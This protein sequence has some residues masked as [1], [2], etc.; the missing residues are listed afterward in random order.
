MFAA[1]YK[2]ITIII[3]LLVS[4]FYFSFT[5]FPQYITKLHCLH[6]IYHF[7]PP[8][9]ALQI[10]MVTGYRLIGMLSIMPPL[11]VSSKVASQ[12]SKDAIILSF[13]LAFIGN[14]VTTWL[15]TLLPPIL[16]KRGIFGYDIN[17]R[18]TDAG[19][20]KV[21]EAAGLAPGV[22]FLVCFIFSQQ[23]HYYNASYI[24]SNPIDFIF[25]R[26]EIPRETMA[27]WLVNYNAALATVG[28]ML[29]LGFVDDVLE[30][31]WRVKLV[32]PTIASLPISVAYNGARFI[33]VPTAL[34]W[35]VGGAAGVDIGIL[36]NIYMVMLTIFCTNSI[37]ILAGINGLEAGQSF[38]IA[39]A[40]LLF[41]LLHLS[42]IREVDDAM[43][44]GHLFSA[45]M[46][47]P[48]AACTFA[49]LKVNYYPAK[50][51]VGDTFT[52]FAGATFAVAG[53]LGHYSEILLIF[54]IP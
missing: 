43:L 6:S 10:T 32:L 53:I 38:I 7:P 12:Q 22:G 41:N 15:L 47:I 35:L 34:Q 48:F 31:P 17:K 4:P 29:F 11:L 14:L 1:P 26:P 40:V 50:M 36:Y 8:P 13:F 46:M 33:A 19:K 16:E 9:K 30:V 54:F 24:L 23:L 44:N 5:L 52:Y 42:G 49:L 25:N 27:A 20:I 39:C 3:P 18:G 2:P 28:F 51:F 21:P 45:F 37:N